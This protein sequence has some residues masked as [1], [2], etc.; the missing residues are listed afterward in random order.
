MDMP[1]GHLSVIILFSYQL[2]D[3]QLIVT[4]I[5]QPE[6]LEVAWPYNVEINLSDGFIC[7][8]VAL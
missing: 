1:D 4:R 8:Q 6:S 7:I 5:L 3:I 2:C